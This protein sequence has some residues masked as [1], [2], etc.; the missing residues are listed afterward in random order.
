MMSMDRGTGR[1]VVSHERGDSTDATLVAHDPL[2][3]K[4]R[5][6]LAAEMA[7]AEQRAT[8]TLDAKIRA[9]LVPGLSAKPLPSSD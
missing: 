4:S 3:G 5:Q 7:D 6:D 8:A 9:C 2:M 1:P